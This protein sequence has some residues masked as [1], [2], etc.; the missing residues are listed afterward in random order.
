MTAQDAVPVEAHGRE[1]LDDRDEPGSEPGR[2]AGALLVDRTFGPFFAGSLVSNA[3][4]WFQNLAASVVVYRLT[5]SNTLVG[6]V[7][8][9]QFAAT[10]VLSPWAGVAG[11]RHDRRRL[12]ILAQVISFVGAGGLA[13]AVGILGID[14]LGG[15]APVYAATVVI[16]VGYALGVP[17][18]QALVPQLV[19][20]RDLDG[21]IALS[22]VTFNLARAIGP[23]LAGALIAAAGAGA[24]FGV[25]AAS[26]LVFIVVLL[27]IRPRPVEIA[28]GTDDGDR[29]LR[30]GLRWAR[31]DAVA[32]PVLLATLALGWASDPVNTLSPAVADHLGHSD[33]FVG[34]LVSAFGAGAA[35]TALVVERVRLRL[36]TLA[37]TQL[38]FALVAVGLV[39]LGLTTVD[40]GALVALA[41]AGAGFLLGV[42][43]LNGALQ[44]R[45][46]ESLRGR[47]M[48]LWSVAL[49]GGRPFA[50]LVDGRTADLTSVTVALCVAGVVP[51]VAGVTLFVVAD[52]PDG[53]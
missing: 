21:A 44:R 50:A 31:E 8:V 26:F 49:L 4:N 30:G 28:P 38:G 23:A 20:S 18:I 45:V 11:D 43:S 48:A 47:V 9:L 25:N 53:F 52:Q 41:L 24:A 42:T 37:S 51:L 5:G 12:L 19:A 36:G 34:A 3:G 39:G 16:G 35:V 27:V 1:P 13:L 15:P 10:L 22:S 14:G 46:P 2:G 7:S 33:A 17:M 40:A 29:S 6:V 32:V